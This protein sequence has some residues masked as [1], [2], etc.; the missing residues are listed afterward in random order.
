V[1]RQLTILF[2]LVILA[3]LVLTAC[4][5]A[6][7]EAPAQ[8][9]E[10]AEPAEPAAP[11]ATEEPAATEPP[12]EP[13]AVPKVPIASFDGTSLVAEDCDYGGFFQ[14]IEA[15]DQY[16]V[17]FNLCKTD[18]AFLSKIA[19]SPFAIYP[20]EWI[21][22]TSGDEVRTTEGV[23]KPI[24]TGP[25]MV[26]AWNRGENVTFVKNPNYWGETP[27]AAET[28]VFRWST[29]SAARLLELQSGTIDGFDNVGPD[30][31]AVVEGDANLQL[32]IRPA[33]NVFYIGMTNTF[34]PF[35]DVAFARLLLW[36]LTGSV[37][38]ILSIP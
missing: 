36:A 16:T 9:A 13:T 4:G 38:L 31:F 24:G 28:L 22:A 26:S 18:A 10:P 2:S 34:P 8:T 35:D 15:T 30:D 5:G 19:F 29:E 7:P 33:L 17:T 3:S 23:E 11:A 20:S 27:L 25:Y 37:S 6:A 14:S 32:A 1:K 21:E 12:A